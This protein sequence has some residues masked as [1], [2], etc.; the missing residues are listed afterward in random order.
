M[1]CG[2]RQ[3]AGGPTEVAGGK[4]QCSKSDSSFVLSYSHHSCAE[5]TALAGYKAANYT[6][7]SD[8]QV[9]EIG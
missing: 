3:L 8:I 7:T 5:E 1:L 9:P 4:K 2:L 6:Q